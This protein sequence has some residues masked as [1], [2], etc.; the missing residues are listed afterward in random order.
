MRVGAQT[1]FLTPGSLAA[2]TY[3]RE[4]IRERHRHRYEFVP[5][6]EPALGARG[7]RFTGT[8]EDGYYEIAEI[9]EH[10]WFVGVQFH[11]EFLSNP[12]RPHPLFREFVGAAL[13]RRESRA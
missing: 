1:V 4:E 13:R 11:P 9:P 8:T 10:P 6:F 5:E 3:G 12:L 7:M 2:R